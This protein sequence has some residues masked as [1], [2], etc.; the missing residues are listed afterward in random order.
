MMLA[1]TVSQPWLVGR[2]GHRLRQL[3]H[4][5]ERPK[6]GR[7]ASVVALGTLGIVASA[8]AV[9][10]T[11]AADPLFFVGDAGPLV[12]WSAPL[13]RVVH[14]LAA[15]LTRERSSS[16]SRRACAHAAAPPRRIAALAWAAC[17]L[18][19]SSSPSPMRRGLSPDSPGFVDALIA[20]LWAF[21]VTRIGLI[22]L[23]AVSWRSARSPWRGR[24][25]V[26]RRRPSWR[27]PSPRSRCSGSPVTRADRPITRRPSRHGRPSSRRPPGRRP[28]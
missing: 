13:L 18:G 22:S 28:S 20:N 4:M 16:P 1:T 11:G 15:A 5:S 14:D 6:V 17:G 24:A 2:R 3:V 12:R 26:G 19:G 10:S 7:R 9:R 8:L 27:W 25:T 21:E 23:G